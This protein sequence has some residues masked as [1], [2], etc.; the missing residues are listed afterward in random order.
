MKKI[1]QEELNEVLRLHE[2][3]DKD[4]EKGKRANLCG[5]DL[6]G[7]DLSSKHLENANFEGSNCS[8]TNFEGSILRECNFRYV[9]AYRTNFRN[10]DLR[11][12]DFITVNL[13]DSYL[14][15]AEVDQIVYCL[16]KNGNGIKNILK[17]IF[18]NQRKLNERIDPEINNLKTPEEK[19][20]WVL[21]MLLALDM[22]KCEAIDSLNWKWWKKG[23]DNIDNLKVELVDMLHFL[24]SACQIVGMDEN[25]VYDLYQK[26]NNLNHKRQNEGYKTGE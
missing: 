25:D 8:Y 14:D 13:K 3:W 21:N 11:G 22:E 16:D 15:G 24:V 5:Y 4:E 23:E 19:R 10:C 26:K 1:T 17:E 2:L 12:S 18:D 20:K 7:L 6:S 9:E